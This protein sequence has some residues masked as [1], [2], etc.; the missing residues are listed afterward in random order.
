MEKDSLKI[1]INTNYKFLYIGTL[2]T[3]IAT[4]IYLYL[5]IEY[6]LTI[7]DRYLDLLKI[8]AIGIAITALLYRIL[9]L[10]EA[11]EISRISMNRKK[12]YK[13]FELISEWNKDVVMANPIDGAKILGEIKDREVTEILKIIDNDEAKRKTILNILNFLERMAIYI[14]SDAVDEMILKDFFALIVK[15]YYLGFKAYIDNKRHHYND[16]EIWIRFENLE[17]SWAD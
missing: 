14:K 9:A 13:A 15:T 3:L 16:N 10:Y 4:S 2:L 1:T 17:K 8:L 11:N 6:N 7:L 5:S 12:Q